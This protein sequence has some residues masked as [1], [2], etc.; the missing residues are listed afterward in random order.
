MY[1][2]FHSN[3]TKPFFV[4]YYS[5]EFCMIHFVLLLQNP[6]CTYSINTI[7]NNIKQKMVCIYLF[8]Y[9]VKRKKSTCPILNSQVCPCPHRT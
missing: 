3:R 9:I 5:I 4:L 8:S 2:L 6:F 1:D 7:Q